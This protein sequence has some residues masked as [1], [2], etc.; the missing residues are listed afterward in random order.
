[1][2]ITQFHRKCLVSKWKHDQNAVCWIRCSKAQDQG[3]EFWQTKSFAIMTYATIPG[4]CLDRVT[5]ESGERVNFES[6]ETPR[7]APRVTLKKKWHN[8]H[9]QH[10]TSDTDDLAP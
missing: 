6:L 5:A 1:M 4:D 10:F 3:L 8:Q 7:P 9:Q 2:M